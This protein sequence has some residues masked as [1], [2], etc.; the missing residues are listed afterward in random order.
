MAFSFDRF[1]ALKLRSRMLAA[2]RTITYRFS[3]SHAQAES[4][5]RTG[6]NDCKGFAMIGHGSDP[7][8]I[9]RIATNIVTASRIV[10]AVVNHLG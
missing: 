9:H 5:G 7:L 10:M 2:I 6:S 8:F 4:T 3:K 1:R